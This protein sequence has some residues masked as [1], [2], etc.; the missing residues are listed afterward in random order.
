M[1]LPRPS[2]TITSPMS[3]VSSAKSSRK[4]VR[5]VQSALTSCWV[6][7]FMDTNLI[8]ILFARIGARLKVIDRSSRRTRTADC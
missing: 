5:V 1:T 4:L 6:L 8:T 3:V 2:L 7:L